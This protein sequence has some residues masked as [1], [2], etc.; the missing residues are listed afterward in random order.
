MVLPWYFPAPQLF[1]CFCCCHQ[2]EGSLGFNQI[3]K[4]CF[5]PILGRCYFFLL[6][7]RDFLNLLWRSLPGLAGGTR[8][9]TRFSCS[10]CQIGATKLFSEL[11]ISIS[12]PGWAELGQIWVFCSE[13]AFGWWIWEFFEN[14]VP[15]RSASTCSYR[16][17]FNKSQNFKRRLGKPTTIIY[18][19]IGQKPT[20]WANWS[21][22]INFDQILI[23]FYDVWSHMVN[24]YFLPWSTATF[25]HF[26][27]LLL[28][29]PTFCHFQRLLFAFLIK[30]ISDTP[31]PSCPSPPLFWFLQP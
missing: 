29:K 21:I 24:G 3:W 26:Q 2:E 1:L 8:K 25:Y 30:G 11:K 28:Q 10:S 4:F 13:A 5:L 22:L 16:W 14:K 19:F 7:L 17:C 15:G 20:F 27:R 23:R 18:W 6:F 9:K 12:G 31:L